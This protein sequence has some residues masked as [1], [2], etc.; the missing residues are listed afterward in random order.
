M[1]NYF[2]TQKPYS[3]FD[4]KQSKTLDLINKGLRFL[5]TGYNVQPLDISVDMNTVEQRI[6]YFHLLDS[7]ITFEVPGDI[8]EL[9]C[10]TG[11]C[12]LLFQ[13]MIEDRHT[14]KQLHLFDSF[15]VPFSFK[16]DVEEEL[17][18]N[19]S[20]AGLKLPVVHKGDFNDTLPSELPDVIAFVHIDCGFGGDAIAHRDVMLHC[21]ES[22]YPRMSKNAVCILMD[23]HDKNENAQGVDINP[24]VKLACDLFFKDKPETIVSLYGNMYNHAFFRKK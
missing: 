21:F 12:A 2:I 16:G 20:R 17:R 4:R 6:N 10:F 15:K 13:K 9:G 1:N 18:N 14:T 22:I 19:F 11:Q 7:V 8:V 23:Y 5:K 24:G 3:V